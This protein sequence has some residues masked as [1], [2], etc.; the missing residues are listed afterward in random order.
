MRPFLYQY[1]RFP[2][3]RLITL[4]GLS[5]CLLLGRGQVAEWVER[6]QNTIFLD[7]PLPCLDNLAVD[8]DHNPEGNDDQFSL[9]GVEKGAMVL[10]SNRVLVVGG[11]QM[12]HR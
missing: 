5:D 2:K 11:Q 3:K 1:D 9:V 4:G 7:H 10:I 12:F 8:H 6:Q